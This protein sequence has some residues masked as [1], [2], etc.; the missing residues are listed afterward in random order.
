MAEK[1]QICH[2]YGMPGKA[3]CLVLPSDEMLS[4][5]EAKEKSP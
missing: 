5:W 1:G 2:T 3:P 4:G